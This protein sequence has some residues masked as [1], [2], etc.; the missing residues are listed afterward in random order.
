MGGK[1]IERHQGL[2]ARAPLQHKNPGE[3]DRLTS[4]C[5]SPLGY[6]PTGLGET[7]ESR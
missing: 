2:C 3:W 5:V 4:L 7:D 6:A 1:V